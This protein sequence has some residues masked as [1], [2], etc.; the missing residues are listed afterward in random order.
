VRILFVALA[1]V[2]MLVGCGGDDDVTRADWARDADA[3]CAE[4]DRRLDSLGTA[5]ELPELA[6]LLGR[7]I[8]LLGE[9]RED[10]ARLDV[11]EGDE[12]RIDQMFTE[13]NEAAAAAREARAAASR[14]D[15][16]AVSVAIGESDGAAA[17]A[18]HIA[19]DLGARTCAQP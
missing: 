6:R 10:L 12:E 8:A 9:E 11:P 15:E 1:A 19:R 14:G 7:A 18:Q 17:Q 16:Q 4:Y 2:L 5:D 13:L 3:I